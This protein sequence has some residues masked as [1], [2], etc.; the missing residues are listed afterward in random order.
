MTVSGSWGIRRA[1][2]YHRPPQAAALGRDC[3]WA[4]QQRD[5]LGGHCNNPGKRQDGLGGD[6]GSGLVGGDRIQDLFQSESA[7]CADRLNVDLERKGGVKGESTI[8]NNRSDG[9]ASC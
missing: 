7:R 2:L 1:C 5:Q 3:M 4:E 8:L 9:I 6:G